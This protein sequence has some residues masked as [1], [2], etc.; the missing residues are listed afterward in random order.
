MNPI[1]ILGVLAVAVASISMMISFSDEQV[2]YSDTT[3]R[4]AE[5]QAQ[6]LQE[7][8]AVTIQDGELRLKNMGSVPIHIREIRILDD[9]GF[10]IHTQ[11]AE[12]TI[13]S[14]QTHTIPADP[15]VAD[16]IAQ[17]TSRG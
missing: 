1:V 7:Q 5:M 4:T 3:Q 16:A 12:T 15:R 10:V 8:A 14:S 2:R 6:R 17:I 13:L 11:K 9:S